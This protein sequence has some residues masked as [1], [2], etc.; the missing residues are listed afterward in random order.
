[1]RAAVLSADRP[2]LEVAVIDDPVPGRGEVVVDVTACGICGSDLHVSGAVAPAGAV[3]G[4]EIAGV[5]AALGAG[6]EG[7]SVGTPVT[8]RPFFGCGR[9]EHCARGR[10]DHCPQFRLAGL[11]AIGGFAERT[12]LDAGELFRLPAAVTGLE[13]ALVEPFAVAR[14]ALRRGGLVPGDDV[15]ILGAGPI[16]LASV[17]WARALGARRVVVSDPQARRRQLALELGADEAVGPGEVEPAAT[18]ASLVV[19]CSGAPGVIDQ[20]MRLAA[21]DGRVAVV[22]ICLAPDTFLPWSGLH[23]E[24]D[25]RFAMY[26][27]RDD[28][29]ETIDAF[30]ARRIEP[31]PMITETVDLDGLPARFAE[32]VLDPDAGK[33]VVVP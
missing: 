32:L 19:E 24:L 14:R 2:R 11:H 16:G 6:V 26:Y 3:L 33:V 9:C 29:T 22:G 10:Q 15:A 23:K 12:V 4:H 25:V 27:G 17:A 31:A 21:I 13:Q 28:F 20:A 5:I 7:W 1:M 18:G 30:A 8:A